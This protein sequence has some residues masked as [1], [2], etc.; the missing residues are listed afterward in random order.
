MNGAGMFPS[1]KAGDMTPLRQR[2]LDALE[3]RG[4]AVRTHKAYIDAV[5]RLGRHFGRNPALLTGAEVQGDLLH[6]LRHR[7]LARASVNQYGCAVRFPC[8]T[9]L[10][11]PHRRFKSRFRAHRRPCP[12]CWRGKRRRSGSRRLATSRPAAS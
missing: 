2:V 10:A 6:L 11:Q 7:H 8:G 9:V 4:M 3:L 5:A 12:R 1:I